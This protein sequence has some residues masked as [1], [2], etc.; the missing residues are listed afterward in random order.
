MSELQSTEPTSG[1]PDAASEGVAERVVCVIAKDVLDLER[2]DTTFGQELLSALWRG[3]WLLIVSV[4]AFGLLSLVYALVATQWFLAEVVL[5][6]ASTRNSQGLTSQLAGLGA[7]AEL[8]DLNLGA[9]RNSDEPIAVLKSRDFARQFIQERDLLLVLLRD[10]WDAQAGRWKERDPHRQP[11]VRDAVRYFDKNVLQ[12]L[13]DKRTGLVT[14]GIRWTSAAQA[15]D[16]ANAIVERLNQ[17]MRARALEEGEAN[18]AYLQ[19]ELSTTTEIPVQQAI[20]RLLETE[21]QGVMVARGRKEFSFRVVDPAMVPKL[22][23]WPKRTI[24]VAI[25]ILAG[26]FF[27]LFAVFIRETFRGG[28]SNRQ[29]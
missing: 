6:P 11:D 20:A 29:A 19:K 22:R 12:V 3:R 17:Q 23:D 21:I 15:A 28:S 24:I 27:G 9:A 1:G 10:Q 14:V 13:E 7:I 8:A 2:R 16:W 25:G 4:L 5:T 18:V 26:G